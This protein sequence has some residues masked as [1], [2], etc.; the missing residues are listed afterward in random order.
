MEFIEDTDLR[1]NL[2]NDMSAINRTLVNSEWKAAT[3][4]AGS[5]LE[6]LL[7]WKLA[8]DR[9][10]AM[11]TKYAAQKK[12]KS[13]ED[14]HLLDYIETAAELDLLGDRTANQARLAKDFRNLIHP[15]RSVRL[16]ESC[17]RGTALGAVAAVELV[18]EDISH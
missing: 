18:I 9:P 3:V 11:A 1:H 12:L 10:Q 4:L 7:L 2:R 8:K 5:I 6:A 13:L 17:N 15:G 14:W 16:G